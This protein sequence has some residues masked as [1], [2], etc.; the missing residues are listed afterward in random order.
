MLWWMLRKHVFSV[1]PDVALDLL[2]FSLFLWYQEILSG[3]N[4]LAVLSDCAFEDPFALVASS[5]RLGQA[6]TYR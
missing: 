1:L 5:D 2:M 6:G 3:E 4:I